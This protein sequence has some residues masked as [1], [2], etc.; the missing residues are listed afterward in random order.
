V[1]GPTAWHEAAWCG[2]KEF[3][4]KLWVWAREVKLNL[5][6]DLLLSKNMCRQIA[7]HIAAWL[8]YKEILEKLCVRAGEVKPNHRGVLLQAKD[9]DG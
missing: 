2:Y 6:G 1:D 9:D 4:E 7:W 3:V 5:R 8:G